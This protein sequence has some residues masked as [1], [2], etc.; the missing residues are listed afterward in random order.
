MIS[1]KYTSIDTNSIGSLFTKD[2]MFPIV[3]LS[4]ILAIN[5]WRYFPPY[6]EIAF[7]LVLIIASLRRINNIPYFAIIP[8]F[9]PLTFN[10]YRPYVL[11]FSI[12]LIAAMFAG[13]A[14]QLKTIFATSVAWYA[15][16]YTSLYAMAGLWSLYPESSL[17][18]TFN[19]IQSLVFLLLLLLFMNNSDSIINIIKVIIF[20]SGIV[21]FLSLAH[22]LWRDQMWATELYNM[23]SISSDWSAVDK[24][25]IMFGQINLGE[26]IIIAS[27]EPNY[28][29]AQLQFPLWLAIGMAHA[30]D[31]RK[32]K[33]FWLASAIFIFLG[34]IGTYSRSSFLTVL[35]VGVLY[36]ILQG[37]KSIIPLI[38]IFIIG[39]SI[40]IYNEN[41]ITRFG[42]I[43]EDVSVRGGSGRIGLWMLAIKMWIESPIFGN[44][45]FSYVSQFGAVHNTYIQLLVE[46]GLVG[47]TL[48]L[49]MLYI[50]I[51]SWNGLIVIGKRTA[52]N[53]LI[54]IGYGGLLG[55]VA[56]YVN[57]ASISAQDNKLIFLPLV[58][59]FAFYSHIRY[60]N[61]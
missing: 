41:M 49:I 6:S 59:G 45:L 18:A 24:Y 44:G 37:K 57:I 48:Y 51:H 15:T 8:I 13:K 20:L 47:L 46:V 42:G 17:T 3:M 16:L 55:T 60:V 12:L 52:N 10:I 50:G 29:G 61:E 7:Y 28:W 5:T 22:S 40:I 2:V 33:Y 9:I 34:I 26:R 58:I 54:S 25:S 21:F 36:I 30:A 39:Y 19:N 38:V 53:K 35:G 23:M 27:F 32:Q 1:S 56:T 4:G 14:K 31:K 43:Q 11:F